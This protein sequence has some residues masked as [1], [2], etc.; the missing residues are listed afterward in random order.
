MIGIPKSSKKVGIGSIKTLTKYGEGT[1][2]LKDGIEVACV[3]KV[4]ESGWFGCYFGG[5]FGCHVFD[6]YGF[7]LGCG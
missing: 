7:G 6:E 1:K 2:A 5:F 4:D 3:P